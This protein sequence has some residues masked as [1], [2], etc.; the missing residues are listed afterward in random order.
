MRDDVVEVSYDA[1]SPVLR[2]LIAYEPN[3]A[4][5]VATPQ[6]AVDEILRTMPVVR[7]ELGIG[8]FRME[9]IVAAGRNPDLVS[10]DPA[11]GVPFGMGST[12]PLIPLHLDGV[13][14]FPT[15]ATRPLTMSIDSCG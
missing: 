10:T 13:L 6:P 14:M 11:T 2:A 7:W 5:D 1:M 8:F 3:G 12:D 15:S 9:D 4:L